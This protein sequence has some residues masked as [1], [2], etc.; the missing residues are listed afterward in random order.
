[1]LRVGICAKYFELFGSPA[2]LIAYIVLVMKSIADLKTVQ[3]CP[4]L[5]RHRVALKCSFYWE[6]NDSSLAITATYVSPL[7]KST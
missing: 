7:T 5:M 2:D 4:L 6:V 1:M 3:L